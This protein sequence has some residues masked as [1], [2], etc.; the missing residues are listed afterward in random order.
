MNMEE[1]KIKITE[2]SEE[3]NT[4][5]LWHGYLMYK[6]ETIVSFF[7]T[8]YKFFILIDLEKQQ[9]YITG[10]KKCQIYNKFHQTRKKNQQQ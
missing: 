7:V 6:L 10:R 2:S 5:A 3:I 8:W 1:D 9:I 4:F